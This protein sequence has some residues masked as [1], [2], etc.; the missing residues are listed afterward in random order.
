MLSPPIRRELP[1]IP[2]RPPLTHRRYPSAMTIALGFLTPTH[3]VF[4]ADSQED[5]GFKMDMRKIAYSAQIYI[6]DTKN[7]ARRAV[8]ITGAG[9]SDYLRYLS[10]D[11]AD[12]FNERDLSVADF[13]RYL[14]FRMRKFYEVHTSPQ[15]PEWLHVELIVAAQDKQD[16]SMWVTYM[17]TVRRVDTSAAVGSG[18]VWARNVLEGFN[19]RF[20]DLKTATLFAAYAAFAA[21][22]H[23]KD[24]GM[25]TR[26]LSLALSDTS[27]KAANWASLQKAEDL[28]REYDYGERMAR[29][30][31][32]GVPMVP[33][34]G[35]ESFHCG[36]RQRLSEIDF[37]P[38]PE[39]LPR[40][41]S[42][43]DGLLPPQPSPES[44]GGSDES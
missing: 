30:G 27:V 43:T 1:N 20:S 21:K 5:R 23:D 17:G 14:R 13:G 42:T 29:L 11:L 6:D 8:A 38:I 36:M 12:R 7:V 35:F 39:V 10:M 4:A 3:M 16:R 18:H 33:G 40:P 32:F 26:I 25:D 22:R 9:N 28:F 19:P 2:F 15:S 41:Q 24:C 31:A 44:P 34:S 37:Y